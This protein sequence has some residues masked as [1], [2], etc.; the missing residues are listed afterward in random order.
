MGLLPHKL[1]ARLLTP[2]YALLLCPSLHHAHSR[3]RRLRRRCRRARDR[4]HAGRAI[5]IVH[6]QFNHARRLDWP[7]RAA[8]DVLGDEGPL[9]LPPDDV[10]RLSDHVLDVCR[11]WGRRLLALR[12]RRPRADHRGYG[13]NGHERLL[14]GAH[15]ARPRLDHLQAVLRRA[16]GC[17]LI[18]TRS[19]LSG[20]TGSS[21][22]RQVC[23]FWWRL[24]RT[25]TRRGR[26]PPSPRRSPSQ[27]ASPPGRARS[28]SRSAS[29]PISSTSPPSSAST[30]FSSRCSSR[31]SSSLCCTARLS[32]E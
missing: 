14:K 24:C 20:P 3:C 12:R 8:A 22:F 1:A 28:S 5:G 25:C 31:S 27:C 2:F 11:R 30:L 15:D 21:A 23:S 7:C 16:D 26:A 19:L 13:G 17:A 4:S 10:R 29:C 9:A 18:P 6:E 32:K